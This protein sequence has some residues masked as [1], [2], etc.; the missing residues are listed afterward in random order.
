VDGLVID[1]GRKRG[2]EVKGEE[3]NQL[4]KDCVDFWGIERQIRMMQEE[5]AELIIAGSHFLRKRKTGYDELVEELADAQLMIN[6]IK[7]F[8]GE[9]S[10]NKMIDKKSDYIKEKLEERRSK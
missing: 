4:Y 10:V 7:T 8:V 6:Q 1:I 2:K 3:L 5:C 9:D